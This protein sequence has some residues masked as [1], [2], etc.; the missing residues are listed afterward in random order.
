MNMLYDKRPRCR[1]ER[2][3]ELA[4]LYPNH[5]IPRAYAVW[6]RLK[7]TLA[8]LAY[9][10]QC[11]GRRPQVVPAQPSAPR[12]AA[13][14]KGRRGI[15]DQRRRTGGQDAGIKLFGFGEADLSKSEP[16]CVIDQSQPGPFVRSALEARM[17][18]PSIPLR[19]QGRQAIW[20]CPGAGAMTRARKQAHTSSATIRSIVASAD[21]ARGLDNATAAGPLRSAVCVGVIDTAGVSPVD[22]ERLSRDPK[23]PGGP[24]S[25]PSGPLAPAAVPH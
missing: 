22:R 4:P 3:D 23:K 25:C 20:Q 6:V 15:Q 9:F 2:R 16:G 18:K 13:H 10:A 5:V 1:P 21:F 17:N 12:L 8:A 24:P 7:R 11:L 19:D 14:A